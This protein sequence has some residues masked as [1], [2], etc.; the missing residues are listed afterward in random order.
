VTTS[1]VRNARDNGFWEFSLALYAQPNVREQC[2]A[3]QQACAIDV[4]VL[5]FCGW[6]GLSKNVRLEADDLAGIQGVITDW[7]RSAVK[8]L[9]S[10]R[11][12]LKVSDV[13]GA[14][15]LREQVKAIELEAERV[16]QAL[17]FSY[18]E[19]KWP[20]G[21]S[22][23]PLACILSNMQMLVRSHGHPGQ[24]GGERR[25]IP[26]VEAALALASRVQE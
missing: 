22:G 9:R 5:L 4:N 19:R 1:D 25:V 16:E 12:Y 2:L 24:W 15:E 10:V 20:H 18:A 14:S 3:L 7:H 21:G 8:P 17:L 11:Q 23:E 13:G 26:I 6:L